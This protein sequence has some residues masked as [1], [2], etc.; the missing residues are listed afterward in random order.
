[1]TF[2]A[3]HMEARFSEPTGSASIDIHRKHYVQKGINDLYSK[4]QFAFDPGRGSD[5]MPD[6]NPMICHSLQVDWSLVSVGFE[7][8]R[9]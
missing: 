1:M 9:G 5:K 3:S 7:Q 6:R 8:T 2:G 4:L